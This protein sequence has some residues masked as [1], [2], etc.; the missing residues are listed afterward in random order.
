MNGLRELL[1]PG[2]AYDPPRSDAADE[3]RNDEVRVW[4]WMIN[5]SDHELRAKKV[6]VQ[7]TMFA[8]PQVVP[9]DEVPVLRAQGLLIGVLG[10]VE[11]DSDG[12]TTTDNEVDKRPSEDEDTDQSKEQGSVHSPGQ[13]RGDG[14]PAVRAQGSSSS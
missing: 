3:R 11:E 14:S 10:I 6:R 1:Y 12:S 7:V 2:H 8:E 5:A 4:T 13:V 9:G